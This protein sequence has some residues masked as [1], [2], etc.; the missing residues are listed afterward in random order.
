MLIDQLKYIYMR[1]KKQL[2]PKML[3]S[4]DYK[5]FIQLSF[6]SFWWQA[7]EIHH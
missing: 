7:G 1:E 3:W 5:K 2:M 4:V 6:I